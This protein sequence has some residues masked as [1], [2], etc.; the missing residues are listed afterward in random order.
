[1]RPVG[2]NSKVSYRLR[3]MRGVVMEA[4]LAIPTDISF[5][6]VT[7]SIVVE[8]RTQFIDYT[9]KNVLKFSQKSGDSLVRLSR[10]L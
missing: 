5:H 8:A 3:G 4:G 6:F 10:N 9:I 1:L 2:L 7:A